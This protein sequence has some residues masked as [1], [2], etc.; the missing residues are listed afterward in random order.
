VSVRTLWTWEHAEARSPGR[1]RRAE[2][3]RPAT[4]AAV[5][6]LLAEQ[7]RMGA[8]AAWRLLEQAHPL[9]QVRE[10]VKEWKEA[11]RLAE[12]ERREAERGH[13]EVL[14]QG[15]VWCLDGTHVGRDAE[16][17]AVI[18][19]VV[20]DEGTRS[21]QGVGAGVV[22]TLEGAAAECGWPL[23]LREDNGGENLAPEVVAKLAEHEVIVLRN[24]PRVPQ[25]NPRAE[26]GMRE[27]KEITGLGKG[28]V[29]ERAEAEARLGWACGVLNRKPRACL[30]WK[31]SVQACAD[32][33][34][35][36]SR[37]SREEFHS[38]ACA[39]IERAVQNAKGKRARRA[40][41]REATLAVLEQFQL[42]K[43]WQGR[44]V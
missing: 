15:A 4:R 11:R 6:A 43:R 23:L 39:A 3:A 17:K 24:Q 29:V 37:V 36:Y 1:P 8:L 44:P 35:W 12:R 27:L 5:S 41:E 33:P 13:V 30:G 32:L 31:S 16:G 28:C 42:I 26:R 19:E 2:A 22:G 14:V 34:W 18:E 25:H 40:A 7:G 21:F 20:R 9:R 38:T 10:V